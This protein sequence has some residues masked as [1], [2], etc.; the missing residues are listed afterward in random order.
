MKSIKANFEILPLP[1]ANDRI[2]VM[3][4]LEKIGRVCYKSEDKITN[5]SCVKFIQ[6]LRDRK[7]WAMLEHYNFVMSVSEELYRALASYQRYDDSNPKLVHAIKFINITSRCHMNNYTG[8]N[9]ISGSAT[10]FN[11]LHESVLH[12]SSSI[13][14]AITTICSFLAYHHSDLMKFDFPKIDHKEIHLL[15]RKEINDLPT[16]LR[17]I[18]DFVSIKFTVDRGVTHELVRHRP[19]SWAQES[20]RYCNYS[21][22]KYNNEISVIDPTFF[23]KED[24][25]KFKNFIRKLPLIGKTIF[26]TKRDCWERSCMIS[27]REY[28][29]LLKLG[30]SP[31]EARSI[32]PQ[33]TKAE[34]VMTASLGEMRHFLNMRV[35]KTA[36]PQ[37]REVTI[38]LFY[39]LQANAYPVFSDLTYNRE[40]DTFGCIE[41]E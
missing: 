9:I 5:D 26:P 6:T 38:P 13:Q 22:G 31:Q 19:C 37:M 11:Y 4:H 33:S 34:I 17:L 41:K 2:G 24:I 35:P 7:H 16:D 32:L 8:C 12:Q 21:Q 29:K 39:E 1:E 40:S 25:G 14:N 28:L 36:H 27:E 23:P 3:M 10:A 20:T 15:S 30:A 18:H